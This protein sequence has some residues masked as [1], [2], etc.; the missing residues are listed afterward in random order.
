M[1][2]VTGFIGFIFGLLGGF[3]VHSFA[4][5]VSFKQRTID[6][7]IKVYDT[8]IAHW[9]R[10]R[11]FIYANH[12]GE[13]VENVSRQIAVTFDQMYGD[14]QTYIGEAILVCEDELLTEDINSLNERLYRT[15]WH[16]LS[17]EE[18][19]PQMEQIKTDALQIVARMRDDIKRSTR[20]ELSDFTHMFSGFNRE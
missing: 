17:L 11:N 4:M 13:P 5:K 1:Q 7:K 18:A 3:F 6:N 10:M 16:R 19:N 20:F 15:E 8:I 14:S 9:V 2:I 12:P